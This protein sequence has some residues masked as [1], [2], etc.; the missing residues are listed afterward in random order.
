MKE[1]RVGGALEEIMKTLRNAN[2]FIDLTE[3]WNLN[4]D[5]TKKDELSGVLYELVETIRISAVLLQALSL[6]H[7]KRY[8]HN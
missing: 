4:K 2:R 5:E 7:Q 3:P 8:F 6:K 1:Y